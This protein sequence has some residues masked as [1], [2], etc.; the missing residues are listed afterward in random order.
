MMFEKV[1]KQYNECLDIVKKYLEKSSIFVVK[2]S[3][4]L[5]VTLYVYTNTILYFTFF[6]RDNKVLR[7]QRV[8]KLQRPFCTYPYRDICITLR[9]RTL[10][11]FWIY[12]FY[13]ASRSYGKS[14]DDRY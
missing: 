7:P 10:L 1:K 5:L 14:N 13:M 12:H 11:Y 6:I 8:Q 2:V 9:C 3:L 4:P